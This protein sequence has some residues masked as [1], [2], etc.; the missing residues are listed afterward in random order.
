MNS[1]NQ[2]NLVQ[3]LQTALANQ[4]SQ[5]GGIQNAAANTQ[6]N[7]PLGSFLGNPSANQASNLQ[8][9][10]LNALGILS[11]LAGISN[12]NNPNIKQDGNSP[13]LSQSSGINTLPG[14]SVA[15]ANFSYYDDAYSSSSQTSSAYGP[16][17]APGRSDSKASTYRPY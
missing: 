3:L 5:Q 7:N 13:Q 15:S 4:N 6:A 17:R 12:Q 10:N 14:T 11:S 9:T 1:S 2:S 16:V 8:G